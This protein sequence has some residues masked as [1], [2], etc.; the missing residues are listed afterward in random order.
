MVTPKPKLAF[1]L[2]QMFEIMRREEDKFTCARHILKQRYHFPLKSRVDVL[3]ARQRGEYSRVRAA[4]E[5]GLPV[6]SLRLRAFRGAFLRDLVSSDAPQ[7]P[8]DVP[9]VADASLKYLQRLQD[10]A[11]C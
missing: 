3:P 8:G 11:G 5:E 6:V 10:F 2:T 1:R 4:F 9:R 7:I